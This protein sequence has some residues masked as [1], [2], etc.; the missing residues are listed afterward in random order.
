MR[1]IAL[2][3]LLLLVA[4]PAQAQTVVAES[5]AV[6]EYGVASF[7][8]QLDWRRRYTL[9]I[10]GPAGVPVSANYVQVYVSRSARNG[11]TGNQ[12]GSFDALTPYESD[13]LSPASNLFF[14]RYSV[15]VSPGV[16]AEVTVRLLDQGP[17]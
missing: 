15:V 6:G 5:Q 10:D 7:Q 14:W 8:A 13:L 4:P 11:G 16:A 17:R 3:L 2:S 9:Q 12:D 1:A